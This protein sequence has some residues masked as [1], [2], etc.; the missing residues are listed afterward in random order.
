MEGPIW[1]LAAPFLWIGY[2]LS[3]KH[4]QDAICAQI[5][6]WIAIGGLICWRY[7]SIA[8][9]KQAQ[10]EV[11]EVNKQLRAEK[12]AESTRN[13]Q[14]KSEMHRKLLELQGKVGIYEG[15]KGKLSELNYAE[16]GQYEERLLRVLGVI[17]EQKELAVK[18]RLETADA[19]LCAI[20]A[21]G[22]LE[23]L[24]RPCRHVCCCA[25]CARRLQ[26]CP[27]CRGTIKAQEKIFL[28]S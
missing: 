26:E 22:R 23:V 11:F 7:L 25:V 8:H 24:F 18:R 3:Q 5:I 19:G 14:E 2:C 1:L 4:P 20:C 13:A 28:P 6:L 21:Q 15:D 17:R 27:M 9:L 16:L 10:K 12:Q